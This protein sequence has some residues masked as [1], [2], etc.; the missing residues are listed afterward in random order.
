MALLRAVV[1]RETEQ[2]SSA[3]QEA[4]DAGILVADSEAAR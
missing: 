3:L 2:L 4:V 1:D